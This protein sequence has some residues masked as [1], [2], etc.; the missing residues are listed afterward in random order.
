MLSGDWGVCRMRFLFFRFLWDLR[1]VLAARKDHEVEPSFGEPFRAV[2][3][4]HDASFHHN[5]LQ[6]V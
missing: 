1:T 5:A 2:I 3:I 6:C 4:Y